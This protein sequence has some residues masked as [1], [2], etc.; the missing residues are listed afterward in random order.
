[1]TLEE[2]IAQLQNDAPAIPRLGVPAYEWWNEA[3][4]GV[5]R[6]GAATVFPQAI[7]L[8]ATF[9]TRADAR[10]RH[11][12]QRR[13]ARQAPRVRAAR[14][15]RPLPGAHV[16]VA[17]HQHLPRPALGTRPGN[18]RRGPV[19]HRA[20]GR[21]VREG[22]AGRRPALPAR[23]CATAK[24]Y[25]VHS[26]PEADRHHFDVRPSERD[27]YETYLPA[28][29][30]LVQEGHVDVGDGRL[31]PR[32]RR[33]RVARAR[34]CCSDI[35]RKDWGFEGYVVSDC[36]SIDDIFKHHKIV[37]TPE[38]AAALGVKSGLDLDCGKTYARSARRVEQG[39]VTEAEID[40][41]RCA[42]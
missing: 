35:L 22:P 17:E 38:E 18:L 34:A 19:S 1:M 23:S 15:A 24:H 40:V 5:A 29:R 37:A 32:E 16:L 27:L 4:H 41:R 30:A 10:G 31:Q 33:V 39:L 3:L 2:K 28:F 13:G 11:G 25:A 42:G 8:A 36:D 20:H 6:A 9:D 14:P 12:D 21:R 26:G 7:G